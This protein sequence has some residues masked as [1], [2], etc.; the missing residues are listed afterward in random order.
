MANL[1]NVVAGLLRRGV[2][3]KTLV[4]WAVEAGYSQG[5]TVF[6]VTTNGFVASRLQHSPRLSQEHHQP[7]QRPPN[8]GDQLAVVSPSLGSKSVYTRSK[9]QLVRLTVGKALSRRD[10]RELPNIS[11]LGFDPGRALVPKDS[12]P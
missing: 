4:R 12:P 1:R 7:G 3:R 6:D 5:Y 9:R 11:M 10:I 2:K 8:K